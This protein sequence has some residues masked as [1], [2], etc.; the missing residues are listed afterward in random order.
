MPASVTFWNRLELRTRGKDPDAGLEARIHDPLW[1][2]TRQWQFGEFQGLDAGSPILAT[3]RL[4]SAPVSRV[5]PPGGTSTAYDLTHPL[6]SIVEG[7][8]ATAPT[9]FD[10]AIAGRRFLAMLSDAGKVPYG[11]AYATAYP[12]PTANGPEVMSD[13]V[14]VSL[15]RTLGGKIPSGALLA[16]ALKAAFAAGAPV[17]TTPA[18]AT[19]DVAGVSA[20]CHAWLTWYESEYEATS[21]ACWIAE[22]LEYRV[23]IGAEIPGGE[24]DFRAPD[25]DGQG[26][27]WHDF[28]YAG[29]VGLGSAAQGTIQGVVQVAIPTPVTFP[30]APARRFWQ[31]EDAAVDVGSIDAAPDDLGRMLLVEFALTF[32]SDW[33]LVPVDLQAGTFTTVGSLVVVNTFGDRLLIRPTGQAFPAGGPWDAFVVTQAVGSTSGPAP[34]LLLTP[35]LPSHVEGRE[36]EQVWF[37]RDDMAEMAWALEATVQGISGVPRSRRDERP[38]TQPV[39]SPVAGAPGL[40]YQLETDVP[41]YWIPVVPVPVG[42]TVMLQRGAML[43]FGTDGSATPIEP[44]GRLLQPGQTLRIFEEE[45]PRSGTRLTRV[46][47]VTRWLDGSTVAWISRR[48]SPGRG[49]GSSGLTF[50]LAVPNQPGS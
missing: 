41:P 25:Y 9:I 29:N 8:A 48:N 10:A 22:R 13:A 30:G 35:G 33:Y 18:V 47:V 4:S 31:F 32:G 44:V 36:L 11:G 39:P 5:R 49:Q 1:L 34:G 3:A 7:E 20:V 6:E 42:N 26:L 21:L 45:V 12:L 23:E 28:D 38:I 24:A 37:L 40:R 43:S 46:P 16:A 50:D 27:D 14:A 2:L 19:V 17:P 15:L